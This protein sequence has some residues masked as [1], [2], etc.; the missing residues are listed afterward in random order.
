MEVLHGSSSVRIR[1]TT[2]NPLT[3]LPFVFTVGYDVGYDVRY[4]NNMYLVV[5]I[6]FSDHCNM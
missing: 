5:I 2:Q 4:D 3:G 6:L 1:V